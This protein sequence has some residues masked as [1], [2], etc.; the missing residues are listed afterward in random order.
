MWGCVGSY[1]TIDEVN[2]SSF[3]I[4]GTLSASLLSYGGQS[5]GNGTTGQSDGL[6]GVGVDGYGTYPLIGLPLYV[7]P[8]FVKVVKCAMPPQSCV[9]MSQGGGFLTAFGQ[10]PSAH[11]SPGSC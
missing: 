9:Y 8:L 6:G 3:L 5:L 10:D 2:R 1:L 7:F 11:A 4:A